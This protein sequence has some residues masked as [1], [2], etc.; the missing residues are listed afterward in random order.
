[1]LSNIEVHR[2][3]KLENFKYS[4]NLSKLVSN[5][6]QIY[7]ALCSQQAARSPPAN[8]VYCHV[9]FNPLIVCSL[10]LKLMLLLPHYTC[11]MFLG[12]LVSYLLE[13]IIIRYYNGLQQMALYSTT[14][15]QLM[16]ILV[17]SNEKQKLSGKW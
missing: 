13:V 3:S 15:Q 11:F 16:L 1:M 5:E 6:K 17:I 10:R 4:I 9:N 7:F 14:Q 12:K 8:P 2:K